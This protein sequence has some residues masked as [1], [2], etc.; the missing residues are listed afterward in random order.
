MRQLAY[1]G[2]AALSAL[3]LIG[4]GCGSD[5]D[6]KATGAGGA[7]ASAGGGSSSGGTTS[8][9][10]TQPAA[11]ANV[12]GST[13]SSAAGGAVSA[14]GASMI[15]GENLVTD[16]CELDGGAS[17]MDVVGGFYLFGD[18]QSCTLPPSGT[19]ACQTT[20]GGT[21]GGVCLSGATIV[22]S[23]YAAW[24]CGMGLSLNTAAPKVSTDADGGTEADG[25]A[26]DAGTADK[27]TYSGPA[28]CF[29][30]TFTGTTGGLTLRVG[31][32]QYADPSIK[33]Q[34]V[35][36]F[37]TLKAFT[38]GWTGQVCFADVTCPNWSSAPGQGCPANMVATPSSSYDLQVQVPGGASASAYEFCLTKVIPLKPSVP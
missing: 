10:T 35:A 27:R 24:G 1:L 30:L 4:F 6:K 33:T 36:P 16:K 17:V 11:G 28:T 15:A 2:V 25:G 31:F 12:G 22:D 3:T 20:D 9:E 38:N 32:T 26:A 7:T 29:E 18:S 23:T 21:T 34:S 8:T 13:S 37:K 5:N 14:A 19:K